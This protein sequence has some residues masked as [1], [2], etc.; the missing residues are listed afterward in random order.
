MLE[1][2]LIPLP[3]II[4]GWAIGG[5]S[6]GPATLAISATSMS[7]GRLAGLQL[8]SGVICGSAVWGSAAALGFAAIMMNTV[9]LFEAVRIAGALYLL[10][11]AIKSLR[12]AWL[13][14]GAKAGSADGL[15]PFRKGILL[16]LTNPKAVFGWGS[17]YAIALVP[18]APPVAVAVLFGALITTSMCV[19]WGYAV[20]FSSPRIAHAYASAK[21]WFELC[22]GLLFGAASLRLLTW[23]PTP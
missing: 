18:D 5:G 12:A 9:W 16:H 23:K 20:L 13:N 10:Y 17:I 21:R 19:F 15:K 4:L 14:K 7:H 8:A 11:L 22:F 2:F 3:L 6:P 1:V